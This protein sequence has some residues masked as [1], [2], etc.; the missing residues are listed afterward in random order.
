MSYYFIHHDI[1]HD[2]YVTSL[3]K[4]E[5]QITL[6]VRSFFCLLLTITLST[7]KQ[8]DNLIKNWASDLL[9]LLP[10]NGLGKLIQSYRVLR[11]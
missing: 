2:S 8:T 11:K 1:H 3:S 10:I 7:W 9:L 5:L 4:R 6:G